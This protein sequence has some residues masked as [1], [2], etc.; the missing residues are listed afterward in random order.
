MSK[1]SIKKKLKHSCSEFCELFKNGYFVEH[2]RTA[3]SLVEAS[4]KRA[5][6]TSSH[7]EVFCEKG[8][9]KNFANLKG[10]HLHQSLF[11]NKVEKEALAQVY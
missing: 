6:Y 7:L 9:L 10:K 11:F 1:I 2:L 5:F 4:N 8:A 3:A